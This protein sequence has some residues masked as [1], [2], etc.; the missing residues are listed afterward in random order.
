MLN[1]GR[2]KFSLSRLFKMKED[3]PPESASAQMEDEALKEGRIGY[4]N[5]SLSE[6]AAACHLNTHGHHVSTYQLYPADAKASL[7]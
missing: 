7:G 2:P 1:A 4:V 3:I 6:L 5:V